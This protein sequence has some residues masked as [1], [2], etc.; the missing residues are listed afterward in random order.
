MKCYTIWI[1]F[2]SFKIS[3]IYNTKNTTMFE[4][5]YQKSFNE[6]IKHFHAKKKIIFD[7]IGWFFWG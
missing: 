5:S 1:Y 4:K 7:A 2:Q 3:D 6:S